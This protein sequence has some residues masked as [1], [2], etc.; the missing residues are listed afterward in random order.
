MMGLRRL[1]WVGCWAAAVLLAAVPA[2]GQTASE[3]TA[4]PRAPRADWTSDRRYFRPGDVI[5]VL[6]DEYTLASAD[7]SSAA[8]EDRRRDAGLAANLRGRSPSAGVEAGVRTELDREFRARGQTTRRDR[9]TAELTARVVAIEPNGGLRIEGTKVITIDEHE[10]EITL[11]GVLRPE[12]VSAENVVESWRLAD[13][14]ISYRS[15]GKLE[16]QGSGLLGR[17]IDWIWP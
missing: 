17:I 15:N 6:V 2:R 16:R 11:R 9:L 8:T 7:K 13:A 4:A 12:D 14:T 1:R 5:T 10:Q 3:G